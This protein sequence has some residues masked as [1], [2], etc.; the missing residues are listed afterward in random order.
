MYTEHWRK[1]KMYAVRVGREIGEWLP[2]NEQC[3]QGRSVRA[4]GDA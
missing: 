1:I 4:L 2:N 3:K